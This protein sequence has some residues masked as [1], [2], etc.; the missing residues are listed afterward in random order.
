MHIKGA[1]TKNLNGV[2][3]YVCVCMRTMVICTLCV[4]IEVIVDLLV[5]DVE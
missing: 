5:R 2:Y 1:Q 3:V 4:R